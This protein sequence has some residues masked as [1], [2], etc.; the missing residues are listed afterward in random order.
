M[1]KKTFFV[2]LIIV[3]FFVSVSIIKIKKQAEH[4]ITPDYQPIFLNTFIQE[5]IINRES[6]TATA[7]PEAICG[8]GLCEITE[9][10]T[11]CPSDCDE[12]TCRELYED[13][14]SLCLENG[15]KEIKINV[16]D[17]E[18]EM[19]WKGPP[20]WKH[21]AIIVMHG[22][23]GVDSNFCSSV[24]KSQNRLFNDV[25]RGVPVEE[26]SELAIKEGFAVFSLNST[27]N[28]VT[29]NDGLSVGKRW[30]SLMQ[31]GKNNID[32]PFIE[33]V[34]VEIVPKMRPKGSSESVFMTG[35]SNGGFMTILA[36]TYFAD[37]ITAFA[38]VSAGDPYGT[39]FDM[40]SHGLI[41]RKCGPGVW[42]DSETNMEVNKPNACVAEILTH[43]KKWSKT[44]RS[45][46]FKQFH[47]QGDG[48]CDISCMQKVGKLLVEHGYKDD[49]AFVIDHNERNF[50]EHFW[51][52]EYNQ[53]LITFFKNQS[54]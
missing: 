9:T 48:A 38:P 41:E 47:N 49:G 23:E 37:R 53:P 5:T 13:T 44:K 46:P 33:K 43:E 10:K 54:T 8:N 50:I 16:N 6:R 7:L 15:W 2:V 40:H 39:Y 27:Y 45:I 42:R 3:V 18:R 51:Q 21:G 26:F 34:I 11:G 19:L 22:G 12:S 25:L 32:L 52:E 14:E 31:E 30:D 4:S 24:P 1:L 36:A 20:S 29:D 28:R 35:I 17:V